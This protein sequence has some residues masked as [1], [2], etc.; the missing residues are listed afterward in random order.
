MQLDVLS[1]LSPIS[2]AIFRPAWTCVITGSVAGMAYLA[3]AELCLAMRIDDPLDAFAVHF[4][5]GLWGLVSA[6]I[7]TEKGLLF[8]LIGGTSEGAETPKVDEA[9]LETPSLPW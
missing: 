6:C 3:F 1:L 9:L 5:G 2:F 7:V 4:G 8:A